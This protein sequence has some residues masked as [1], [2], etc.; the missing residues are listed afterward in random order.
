MRRLALAL[1]LLAAA[2]AVLAALDDDP[3]ASSP[4]RAAVGSRTAA[5]TGAELRWIRGYARW[6]IELEDAV[7]GA[8][9]GRLPFADCA[10]VL[11]TTAGG[12]PTRRLEPAA[13]AVDHAC[14]GITGDADEE[15]IRADLDRAD[16]LLAEFLLSTSELRETDEATTESRSSAMLGGIASARADADVEVL[17]WGDRDW[18]RLIREENAWSDDDDDAGLVDGLAFVEEGRIH[19]LLEDCNVLGRLRGE[20]VSDRN[21]EGLIDATRALTIFAHEIEHFR[22]PEGTESEVE[23]A[24]LVALERVGRPLGLDGDEID[25]FRRV[26]DESVREDLDPEYRKGC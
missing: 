19:M 16:D 4:V 20:R 17:C 15:S 10:A 2:A 9:A 12:A 14:A 11:R 23:C 22:L 3:A 8:R 26:Y 21:R 6:S 7:L 25:L 13:A 5:L 18:R 1:L 24:A